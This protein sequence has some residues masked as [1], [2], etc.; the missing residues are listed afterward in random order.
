[1]FFQTKDPIKILRLCRGVCLLRPV[2]SVSAP[3]HLGL[4][5][6]LSDTHAAETSAPPA[7][8]D[9]PPTPRQI[10]LM[11][12]IFD[13]NALL[14]AMRCDRQMSNRSHTLSHTLIVSLLCKATS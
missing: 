2:S 3:V 14:W 7:F 10:F 11:L 9:G 12:S 8:A 13:S 1:M 6:C 4:H 5:A